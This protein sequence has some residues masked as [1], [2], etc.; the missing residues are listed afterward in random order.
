MK[1]EKYM[2]FCR[3]SFVAKKAK[4]SHKFEEN[5]YFLAN[6]IGRKQKTLA[7]KDSNIWLVTRVFSFSR[8]N[9][10]KIRVLTC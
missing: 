10:Q 5:M 7:S 8:K 3:K 6:V 2:F 4:K 9:R 1:V